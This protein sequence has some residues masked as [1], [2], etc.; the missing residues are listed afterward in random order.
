[1]GKIIGI[2]THSH[3]LLRCGSTG[4]RRYTL[5]VQPAAAYLPLGILCPP[6]PNRQPTQRAGIIPVFGT[7]RRMGPR[8]R[9]RFPPAASLRTLGAPLVRVNLRRG[10]D[11]RFPPCRATGGLGATTLPTRAWC[12]SAIAATGRP[13]E[14]PA[15]WTV[16]VPSHRR[17]PGREHDFRRPLSRQAP[18]RRPSR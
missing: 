16:Q 13:F 15:E 14:K 17:R 18:F 8:V 6:E 2:P 11:N 5:P 4:C 7:A 10:D 1:V 3:A 12:C 9:I